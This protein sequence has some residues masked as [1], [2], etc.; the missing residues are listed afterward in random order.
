MFVNLKSITWMLQNLFTFSE[1]GVNV[2]SLN[3]VYLR[4]GYNF[5]SQKSSVYTIL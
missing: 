4:D 3:Y 2:N 1:A 5:K